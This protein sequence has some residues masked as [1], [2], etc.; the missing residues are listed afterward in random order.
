VLLDTSFSNLFLENL[1]ATVENLL[2]FSNLVVF[3]NSALNFENIL[4]F[5]NILNL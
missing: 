1:G 4:N 3:N 5:V 2:N